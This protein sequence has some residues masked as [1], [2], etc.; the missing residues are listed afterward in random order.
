[1]AKLIV[2]G[3]PGS[4]KTTV[5]SKIKN[6]R[7]ISLS[8][9]MLKLSSQKG[10]NDRDKL[11]YMSYSDTA[12]M[13]KE[14]IENVINKIDEDALIDTHLTVKKK[15][16][17]MPGFS[18]SDLDSFKGL[19]G[20]IYIDAHANDILFRRLADKTRTREDEPE[21]EIHEQRRLN[22]AIA[23]YYSAYLNVPLYI[24]K[25]RQNQPD[26]AAKE[27]EEAIKESLEKSK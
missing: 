25:N 21:E 9:E 4:G 26:L 12:K 20:I 16:R 10:V 8:E 15:A 6:V 22:T 18:Q 5:L 19:C 27:A 13:R 24:I 1:M 3:T 14:V 23:A 2:T 7:I 17:Y 11:R